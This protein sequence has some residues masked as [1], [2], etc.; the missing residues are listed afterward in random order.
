[1]VFH[2]NHYSNGN[3]V[4]QWTHGN[5]TIQV[6]VGDLEDNAPCCN[7]MVFIPDDLKHE[8]PMLHAAALEICVL[9]AVAAAHKYRCMFNVTMITVGQYFSATESFVLGISTIRLTMKKC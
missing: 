7:S 5:N 8:S 3:K 1:M 6:F 4:Y 9:L 2:E